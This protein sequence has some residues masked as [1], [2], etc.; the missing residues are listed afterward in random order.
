MLEWILNHISSSKN[1]KSSDRLNASNSQINTAKISDLKSNIEEYSPPD[2]SK[3]STNV[4]N[5]AEQG[6]RGG[7]FFSRCFDNSDCAYAALAMFKEH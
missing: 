5:H 2:P 6:S 3:P 7:L 1:A 4:V